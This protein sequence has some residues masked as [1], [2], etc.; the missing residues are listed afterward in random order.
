MKN[1]RLLMGSLLVLAI[2]LFSFWIWKFR[3]TPSAPIISVNQETLAKELIVLIHGER[4]TEAEKSFSHLDDRLLGTDPEERATRIGMILSNT[5]E[6]SIGSESTEYKHAQLARE[7]VA[8]YA[9]LLTKPDCIL[10]VASHL[11][12]FDEDFID[13]VNGFKKNGMRDKVSAILESPTDRQYLQLKN[14]S[15]R[16]GVVEWVH[17]TEQT[18]SKW[19]QIAEEPRTAGQL[20]GRL[21]FSFWKFNQSRGSFK[22]NYAAILSPV[23]K[24]IDQYGIATGSAWASGVL[25]IDP[26]LAE[27]QHLN[28]RLCNEFRDGWNKRWEQHFAL[29]LDN[30]GEENWD[31]IFAQFIGDI[32]KNE[33]SDESI[34]ASIGLS[35]ALG[36]IRKQMMATGYDPYQHPSFI[37]GL[38]KSTEGFHDYEL[39]VEYALIDIEQRPL[40]LATVKNVVVHLAKNHLARELS[41]FLY[42]IDSKLLVDSENPHDKDKNARKA[43]AFYQKLSTESVMLIP[44]A[45]HIAAIQ[46]K[47]ISP[48]MKFDHQGLE[49]KIGEVFRRP[50][51]HQYIQLREY[52]DDYD[53]SHYQ[54]L[55]KS[56]TGSEWE[57]L[58][59]D[60]R[61][62]GQLLANTLQRFNYSDKGNYRISSADLTEL[63]RVIADQHKVSTLAKLLAGFCDEDPSLMADLGLYHYPG[64]V[65]SSCW[66]R[67]WNKMLLVNGGISNPIDWRAVYSEYLSGVARELEPDEQW[68]AAIGLYSA[69]KQQLQ[70]PVLSKY[71]PF[72]N[73]ECFAVLRNITADIPAFEFEI[74]ILEMRT[75]YRTPPNRNIEPFD[76]NDRL[77]AFIT[78]NQTPLFARLRF[79]AEL[80]YMLP[81]P[82]TAYSPKTIATINHTFAE[83]MHESLIACGDTNWNFPGG[84]EWRPAKAKIGMTLLGIAEKEMSALSKEQKIRKAIDMLIQSGKTNEAHMATLRNKDLFPDTTWIMS[85]MMMAGAI[86]EALIFLPKSDELKFSSGSASYTKSIHLQSPKLFAR[87][88]DPELRYL[89]QIYYNTGI[90]LSSNPELPSRLDR[91]IPL[92]EQFDRIPITNENRRL[93]C[94]AQFAKEPLVVSSGS[95]GSALNEWGKAHGLIDLQN[96]AKAKQSGAIDRDTYESL[97]I[98][99]LGL[100]IK[101]SRIEELERRID[102]TWP[103][104]SNPVMDKLIPVFYEHTLQHAAN[105]NF[106]AISACA[107]L[108][109]KLYEQRCR[110]PNNQLMDVRAAQV[111]MDF[112]HAADNQHKTLRQWIEGVGGTA[113]TLYQNQIKS[114][115]SGLR[116]SVITRMYEPMSIALRIRWEDPN[117]AAIRQGSL[118]VFLNDDLI[119]QIYTGKRP[120]T[121]SNVNGV[122]FPRLDDALVAIQQWQ[123]LHPA[124]ARELDEALSATKEIQA[125]SDESDRPEMKDK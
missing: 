120:L 76:L 23:R 111:W 119:R 3:T 70:S 31:D 112:C 102:T 36:V 59:T 48:M 51:H 56:S 45:S 87:I 91:L 101:E 117:N 107:P 114:D 82:D 46:G 121:G 103:E 108:S 10:P 88:D 14:E 27:R 21:H 44:A 28:S 47:L 104:L 94:L 39:A 41:E 77:V 22:I 2:A 75:K 33:L 42:K 9:Y 100:L 86:D 115:Q 26:T 98:A 96:P 57:Q 85:G 109:R 97:E 123:K 58:A 6:S 81:S 118:I 37:A 43:I 34:H 53:L 71:E 124:Q 4:Y 106:K 29:H 15:I 49:N 89:L 18:G 19:K 20:I 80:T 24:I 63:C 35:Q 17:L 61:E 1:N 7:A 84:N 78:S 110:K 68:F 93:K 30:L 54:S 66:L 60:P 95:V 122:S 40:E 90:R 105:H 64:S 25:E 116:T 5:K 8:F 67:H 92:A 125:K 79:C 16:D 73:P 12:N 32:A 72:K 69:I 55:W 83:I 74:E 11:K 113:K 99:F 13:A 52:T 62:V 50:T 38:V 65:F